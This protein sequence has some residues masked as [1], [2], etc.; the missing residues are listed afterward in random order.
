MPKVLYLS[1][2]E[3]T[4][5]INALDLYAADP[6]HPPAHVRTGA[7]RHHATMLK[8]YALRIALD[9]DNVETFN[10][11]AVNNHANFRARLTDTP[12]S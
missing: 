6:L 8:G 9:T 12:Q 5:I 11:D 1:Q 4:T 3:L 10:R 7:D 2:R